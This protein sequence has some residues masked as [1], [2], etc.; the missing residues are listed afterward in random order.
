MAF[1]ADPFYLRPAWVLEVSPLNRIIWPM[2]PDRPRLNVAIGIVIEAGQVLIT[3]RPPGVPLAG[4]WEFPGG[5]QHPGE[6]PEQA[7][8][9]E[10]QEELSITVSPTG[11]LPVIQHDY[12]FASI[13][14]TPILCR[15]TAGDP[16][17]HSSSEF[18]WIPLPAL[19]EYAFPPANAELLR[20][21]SQGI[22]T[23]RRPG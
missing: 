20:T 2:E 3:R 7:V 22:A 12:A 10:L 16:M 9:R 8:V 23:D 13:T 17:P 11:R 21:L 6:S 5:K 15:R 19:T 14:L 18:R 1:S 4:L